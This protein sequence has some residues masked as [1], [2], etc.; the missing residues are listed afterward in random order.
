MNEKFSKPAED[1]FDNVSDYI[2]LKADNIKLRT[3]KGLSEMASCFISFMLILFVL[4]MICIPLALI[5]ILFLGDI[6]G[7]YGLSSLIVMAFFLIILVL[8]LIFGK[9]LFAG[10]FVRMFS[11]LFFE[12]DDEEE[13][14]EH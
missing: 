6:L 10:R 1:L 8:L 11:K 5:G 12:K 13:L 3:V 7:S 4:A 2:D 14:Q 9:R